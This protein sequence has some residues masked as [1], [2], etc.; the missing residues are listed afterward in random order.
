MLEAYWC[1]MCC[2]P[3]RLY[4]SNP[5]LPEI[6]ISLFTPS[7]TPII[8]CGSPVGPHPQPNPS[9]NP[10]PLLQLEPSLCNRK[11][12]QH[13]S[14]SS[15]APSSP[16]EVFTAAQASVL[17]VSHTHLR[18][19]DQKQKPSFLGC[20]YPLQAMSLFLSVA[21][22]PTFWDSYSSH[23]TFMHRTHQNMPS[24]CHIHTLPLYAQGFGSCLSTPAPAG[25]SAFSMYVVVTQPPCSPLRPLT[26]Q[27]SWKQPPPPRWTC[28]LGHHI[29][30]PPISN[31]TP[32]S[33]T[34]P[35]Q[36][37]ATSIQ[38]L[39]P[40]SPSTTCGCHPLTA[41]LWQPCLPR[42]E[43]MGALEGSLPALPIPKLADLLARTPGSF[44][45]YLSCVC[46]PNTVLS[47]VPQDRSNSLV[48]CF[49]VY[50]LR[51]SVSLM[52]W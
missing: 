27:Q 31:P 9:S 12:L 4:A 28:G 35:S 11:T 46:C 41:M 7:Y 39:P 42:Q 50:I 17:F 32:L 47:L 16:W 51:R 20:H 45:S 36:P 24:A 19:Q 48:I 34:T 5:S 37:S 10:L 21:Q 38:I 52:H 29:Y 49:S 22:T 2:I 14:I 23:V 26:I 30:S 25:F 6:Q 40:H 43:R 1:G 13:I 8:L 3:T 15:Q 44:P 18:A 33:A